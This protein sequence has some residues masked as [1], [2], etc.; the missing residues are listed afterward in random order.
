MSKY[1]AKALLFAAKFKQK[2]IRRRHSRKAP[3]PYL[4][5]LHPDNEDMLHDP[6]EIVILQGQT[7]W[8]GTTN[9][10]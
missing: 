6:L 3:A 7:S 9:I 5:F 2:C 8:N 10:T 4:M 1:N